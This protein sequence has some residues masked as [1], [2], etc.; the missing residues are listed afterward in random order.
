MFSRAKV[1]LPGYRRAAKELAERQQL[2]LEFAA[3]KW[4]MAVGGVA[5]TVLILILVLSMVILLRWWGKHQADRESA[6]VHTVE[7]SRAETA[8]ANEK[9]TRFEAQRDTARSACYE[10]QLAVV[11]NRADS[12]RASAES[13]RVKTQLQTRT[14]LLKRTEAEKQ[15]ALSACY[16]YQLEGIHNRQ[17]ANRASMAL[18]QA[19][20]DLQ[21]MTEVVARF[22]VQTQLQRL[23]MRSLNA[24]LMKEEGKTEKAERDMATCRAKYEECRSS[25]QS[26][27]EQMARDSAQAE[28]VK[29]AARKAATQGKET[30]PQAQK[31][32]VAQ[33]SH[34]STASD[35]KLDEEGFGLQHMEQAML[36]S[37]EEEVKQ[38]GVCDPQQGKV[39]SAPRAKAI[40]APARRRREKKKEPL[41][42]AS[43]NRWAVFAEDED[44]DDEDEGK[45][46]EGATPADATPATSPPGRGRTRGKSPS[47][48]RRRANNEH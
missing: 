39:S 17:D 13:A 31:Q 16:E 44:D 10:F 21:K 46:A 32:Q 43:T 37:L 33:G 15:T 27:R 41:P 1:L 24:A 18:A 26:A 4:K 38:D 25:L 48:S 28:A 29:E 3:Y 12:H 19:E 9:T 45:G 34:A 8:T 23:G 35:A 11:E 5:F 22:N 14:K 30:G 42:T 6:L 20:H 36:R 40:A 47:P 2:E 7:E